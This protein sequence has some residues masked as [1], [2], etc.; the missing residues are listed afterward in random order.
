MAPSSPDNDQEA[1]VALDLYVFIALTLCSQGNVPTAGVS[2]Q[3]SME[4][5][6]DA[7][8]ASRQT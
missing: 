7:S 5:E 4:E 2:G 6:T 1:Y 3:A 8:Q